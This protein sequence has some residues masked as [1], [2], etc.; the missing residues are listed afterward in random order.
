VNETD[1]GPPEGPSVGSAQYVRILEKLVTRMRASG[2]GNIGV[3]GPDTAYVTSG[4]PD[5]IPAMMRNSA[6]MAQVHHFGLHSYDGD[7]GGT[8]AAIK[9]SRYPTRN[10]WMTE[11]ASRCPGCDAG[12]STR[13]EWSFAK[14]TI[15]HLFRH[16]RDGAAAALV[17]DAYD[18]VYEHHESIGHWGLLS[19]DPASGAYR[20][21]KR[22]YASMQVFRFVPP[23][24]IRIG[25]TA[26]GPD[27]Q[28]QAFHHAG[29]GRTTIVGRNAAPTAVTV[30]GSL[31]NLPPIDTLELYQTTAT[32]NFER[33]ADVAVSDGEF[34]VTIA[35]DSIFTLTSAGDRHRSFE[36]TSHGPRER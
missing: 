11:W 23:G 22:F 26:S 10:F 17:Y 9:G 16:L 6:V 34:S 2:L 14:K 15:Q 33:G 24:S 31:A 3:L 4:V 19:H 5:Y 36:P 8:A 35:P 30:R 18:S 25:A 28:A 20:A 1:L 27:L 29:S 32:R 13:D 12:A 21:R 7:S